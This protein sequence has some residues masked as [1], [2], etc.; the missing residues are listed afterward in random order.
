MDRSRSNLPCDMCQE[1]IQSPSESTNQTEQYDVE[2]SRLDVQ[3]ENSKGVLRERGARC[4]RRKTGLGTPKMFVQKC[5]TEL[6]GGDRSVRGMKTQQTQRCKRAGLE[7]QPLGDCWIEQVMRRKY[8]EATRRVEGRFEEK[9]E[10][11]LF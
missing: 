7:I 11:C 1:P 3:S 2:V 8:I 6:N 4:F 9:T 10:A 5:W